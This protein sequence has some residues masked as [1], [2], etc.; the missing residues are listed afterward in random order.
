MRI[1]E[2]RS[3][4]EEEEA[5]ADRRRKH[6][7]I[8]PP[9][10]RTK[11]VVELPMSLT[12]SHLHQG[13]TCQTNSRGGEMNQVFFFPC[14]SSSNKFSPIVLSSFAQRWETIKQRVICQAN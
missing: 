5:R 14:L 8:M 7:A 13:P 10:A 6:A 2:A 11:R 3:E 9:R 4:E 1:L 12:S